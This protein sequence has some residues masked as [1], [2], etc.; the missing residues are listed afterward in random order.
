MHE[1]ILICLCHKPI[2]LFS[3]IDQKLMNHFKWFI[4]QEIWIIFREE[5]IHFPGRS[6][7]FFQE[8][9]FIFPGRYDSFFSNIWIILPRNMNYSSGKIWIIFPG[10]MNYFSVH[11]FLINSEKLINRPMM[12]LAGWLPCMPTEYLSWRMLRS[13]WSEGL[14]FLI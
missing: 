9:W 3:R 5:M 8:I 1:N 10:N 13:F 2:N 12:I 11:Q 7:S 6:E 4:F 14:E